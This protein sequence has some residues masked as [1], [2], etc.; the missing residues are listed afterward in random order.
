MRREVYWLT[1]A[2]GI[3]GLLCITL[4]VYCLV[5]EALADRQAAWFNVVLG[6]A[7]FTVAVGSLWHRIRRNE[8]R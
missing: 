6:V 4:G 1:H 8:R 2:L 7:D 5:F 3:A